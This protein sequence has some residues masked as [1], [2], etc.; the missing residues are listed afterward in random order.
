MTTDKPS[1]ELDDPANNALFLTG[2]EVI[3]VF[4]FAMNNHVIAL[5]PADVL[6]TCDF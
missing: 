1:V 6:I 5:D 3:S 2:E 4:E